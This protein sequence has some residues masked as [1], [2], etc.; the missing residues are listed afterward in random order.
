MVNASEWRQ[1]FEEW[2][3]SLPSDVQATWALSTNDAVANGTNA[4]DAEALVVTVQSYLKMK[5]GA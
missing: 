3:T 4:A 1:R 2:T 5:L